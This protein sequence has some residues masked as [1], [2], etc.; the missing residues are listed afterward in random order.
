MLLDTWATNNVFKETTHMYLAFC[1]KA[2]HTEPLKPDMHISR[3]II[4]V[5]VNSF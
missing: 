5:I 1:L 2:L 3:Q 4:Y